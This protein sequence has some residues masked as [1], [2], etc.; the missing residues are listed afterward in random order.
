MFRFIG[1]L[2]AVTLLTMSASSWAMSAGRLTIKIPKV[3][4]MTEIGKQGSCQSSGYVSSNPSPVIPYVGKTRLLSSQLIGTASVAEV[5]NAQQKLYAPFAGIGF[6][7]G[8]ATL[9]TFT[10][11]TD[12]SK[13]YRI[14]YASD[15][16]TLSGRLPMGSSSTPMQPRSRS[17]RG[18]RAILPTRLAP[19]PASWQA[20]ADCWRC[21]TTSAT[22]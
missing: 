12:S 19:S 1:R 3:S 10:P 4:A 13:L 2:V 11:P 20:R 15:D 7:P 17:R 5:N 18:R 9:P 6:L 21:P 14:T 8:G 22:V 16:Q